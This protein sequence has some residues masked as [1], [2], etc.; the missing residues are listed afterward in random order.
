MTVPAEA[1]AQR[2][3][4][5]VIDLVVQAIDINALLQLV[6]FNALLARVDVN[7]PLDQVDLNTLLRH[8]DLNAQLA[9][10]DVNAPLDQV[11]LNALLRHVDLNTL[12]DQVD[13]NAV[14]DRIDINDVVGRIDMEKLV[15][16]TDLGAIIARST[17]GIATE[18]L[19]SVRSEA[20]GLDQRVDRWVA[21]LLRRKDPGALGAARAAEGGVS[22]TSVQTHP[23]RWVS[24]QGRHAGAVSRLAAYLIDLIVSSALFE[25]ALTA[26]SFVSQIITGRGI[27]WHRGNI[28]V[29]IIYVVWQFVYFGAQ[30]AG[31]AKTLGMTLLGLHV[32]RADGARLKPWRGWV[33]SLTFPLGFLTL[34]LGFLGILVQRKHRAL[35]DLIAGTAVVY[36]WDARAARLRF[37]ARQSEPI[38]DAAHGPGTA[39]PAAVTADRPVQVDQTDP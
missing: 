18:A 21:G 11:D 27:S 7:A 28:A 17:G 8:V 23:D 5:R 10:V 16:Q 15:E 29:I 32:V 20:V 24:A 1:L 31:R 3:A 2:L 38:A 36:A 33:R 9:R 13:M 4:E 6:D 35:Y 14:L 26:I 12:L 30:W 25:L 19:D 37:L 39:K 34:G 22:A